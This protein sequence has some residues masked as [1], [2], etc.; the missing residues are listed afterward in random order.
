MPITVSR[1]HKSLVVP[2][3]PASRAVLPAAVPLPPGNLLVPH[4]MRETLLLRH[5]GFKVPS[6]IMH[7]D[8]EGGT[9]FDVQRKTVEMLV[10]SPRA[11]VLNH[12]GTGK[13]R[14][15]LWAWRALFKWGLTQKVL[16][17]AP[18]S[19][20]HFVWAREA[21]STIPGVR[22][23]VLH[24]TRAQRLERL[25]VDADVYIINHDG[26]KV[27]HEALSV[28]PDITCLIIDELAVYRN[29]SERS[30]LMRKFAQRFDQIWGMTG[31][32]MPNE[33]TDV[34]GQAKIVTPRTVPKYQSHAR[35][36]LMIRINQYTW[37][38]RPNAVN[39]AFQMLQ[40][41]VRYALDDV[42]EL[43]PVIHRM[44]DVDLSSQQKKV[45]TKVLNELTVMVNNKQIVALNAG[46][47]MGKLLQIAG[48]WVYTKAPDFVRL[49]ASARVSA[50]IDLIE[51]AEQK[52]IV[53]VP[54]RHMIE[55]IAS[56]FERL[57][58]FQRQDKT[59]DYAVVHGDTTNREEIFT[60][61]QNTDKFKF[62]LAHPGCIHH[63]LTLTR[64]DTVIWYLPITSLEVYDQANARITRVG[65]LH[66]QQVLHLQATNVEKKIYRMLRTKQKI[67][68]EL[69]TLLE[70]S[71]ALRD[72]DV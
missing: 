47:A 25:A 55:G 26:V 28:R 40:P 12:M 18:L 39:L 4:G 43:P 66:K 67:Q 22:V 6:P 48:G 54:Y 24:G 17:V 32:P 70:D 64:A 23:Q 9:P 5:V 71:T 19:T 14:S 44:I 36:L 52:V 20:L 63:G 27:I 41:S 31:A 16:V 60:A 49:D 37:R 8:F 69:L 56:I 62:L 50:L 51:S 11:Y 58:L 53:F 33:P 29:N 21:F 2:D 7:Y 3:C 72:G 45:Y 35:E 65:Q 10:E 15:A 42:V 68:N 57:S 38:P 13:T 34:W 59:P 1:K 61:F 30:K 46:A